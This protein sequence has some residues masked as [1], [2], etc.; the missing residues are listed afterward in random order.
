MDR[1]DAR[2]QVAPEPLPKYVS[3]TV[4]P[5][6]YPLFRRLLGARMPATWAQW[7]TDQ[8]HA[9]QFYISLGGSVESVQVSYLGFAEYCWTHALKP[10][11]EVLKT[12]A[13]LIATSP[14][15]TAQDS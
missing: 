8:T 7:Q 11:L 4:L 5:D 12:F 14:P 2:P 15:G 9:S 10:T 3:V 13:E 6:E 1:L